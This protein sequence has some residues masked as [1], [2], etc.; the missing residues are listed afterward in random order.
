MVGEEPLNLIPNGTLRLDT[1]SIKLSMLTCES[2]RGTARDIKMVS[3]V[4]RWSAH[5]L[6]KESDLRMLKEWRGDIL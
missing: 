6:V 1:K 5:N 3:L 4:L 2:A